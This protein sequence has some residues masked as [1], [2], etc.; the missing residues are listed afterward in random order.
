M[1]IFN[2]IAGIWEWENWLSNTYWRPHKIT[3]INYNINYNYYKP[4]EIKEE[5][6]TSIM[7]DKKWE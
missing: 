4:K 1:K 2:E 3:N 6:F 7:F 5:E